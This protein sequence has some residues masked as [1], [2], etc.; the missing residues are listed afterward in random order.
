VQRTAQITIARPRVDVFDYLADAE[1]L[2]DYAGDFIWVKQTSPGAPGPGTEYEYQMKRG[3]HGTFHRSEY[4][5][6][7]TLA[8]AGPPAK[9]GPGAMAPSGRWE[10]TDTP[11]GTATTVTLVMSPSPSGLL[12]LAAPLIFAKIGRDLPIALER[13]KAQLEQ[14]VRR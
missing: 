7:T 14:A 13:L 11:D 9:A 1:Q 4:V 12:T 10:L 6:H 3:V 8:W 5:P 2:P